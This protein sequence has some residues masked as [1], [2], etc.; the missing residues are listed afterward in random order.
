M[1]IKQLLGDNKING[2]KQLII[3]KI[4]TDLATLPED[5]RKLVEIVL[6]INMKTEK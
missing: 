2:S 3:S 6:E 4:N 5:V 1:E